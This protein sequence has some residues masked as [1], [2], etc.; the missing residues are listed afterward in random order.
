MRPGVALALENRK[1]PEVLT[2]VFA[3]QDMDATAKAREY[4]AGYPAVVA[5]GRAVQGWRTRLHDGAP[6]ESRGNS[7]YQIAADLGSA[8]DEHC[9]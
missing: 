1:R 6:P 3:G 9:A 7:A 5:L 4:I 2:T 8:F